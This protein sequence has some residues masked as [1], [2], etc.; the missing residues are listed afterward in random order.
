MVES[1]KSTGTNVKV[2][3]V[4]DYLLKAREKNPETKSAWDDALALMYA[5]NVIVGQVVRKGT[6]KF[7]A[8]A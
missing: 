3:T 1:T 2:V 8:E 4:E 5:D 6:T 7:I